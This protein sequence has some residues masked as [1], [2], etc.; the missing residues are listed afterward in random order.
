MNGGVKG[1]FDAGKV[2]FLPGIDYANPDLSHFHS[3]HFWETGLIT[4]NVAPGW[5][6]RWLDRHGS[7]DNPFQG[8][9]LA[10]GLSPVMRTA[11]APVAAVSSPDDAEMWIRGLWGT[12]YERTMDTYGRIASAQPKGAGPSSAYTAARLAK[13][14]GD[15]L[16]PYRSKN[17]VDPL[18][19]PVAY[20][21]ENDFAERLSRLAAMISLPLGIRVATIEADGD[22]DTHDNQSELTK[23]L[24]DVSQCLAA[25]QADLEARGVADRTLTFVWSEFGRRPEENDSGTDHGAGGVAWVQGNR[26]LAG[27]H[28]DYPDLNRLDREDN[29]QVTIDFRR[30]YSSLL[31][32]HLGTPAS[33]VIP[34][35]GKFGRVQLVR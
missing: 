21:K 28:S 33:A 1:L 34:R 19:P 2:G 10:Y 15:K 5:L 35:A 16:A 18:A 24:A 30:V 6:G 29:L 13:A 7:G 11:R 27:V 14:V 4:P 20:P 23:I 25:F 9:S 3:R 31:E 17:D 22:F 12:A 8:L 32:Q 26:A